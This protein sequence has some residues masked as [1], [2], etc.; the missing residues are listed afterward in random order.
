L[1]ARRPR[2]ALAQ[3]VEVAVAEN[4]GLTQQACVKASATS[5]APNTSGN[6]RSDTSA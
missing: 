3:Q 6:T 1:L 2:S 5:R 4:I